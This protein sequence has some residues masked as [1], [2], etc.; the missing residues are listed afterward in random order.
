MQ[1]LQERIAKEK[2]EKMEKQT[3]LDV[4]KTKKERTERESHEMKE[5]ITTSRQMVSEM[6][7]LNSS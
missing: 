3:E 1:P 7:C 4:L 5:S 2:V 6:V